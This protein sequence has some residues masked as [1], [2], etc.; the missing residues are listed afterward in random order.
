MVA[1][2]SRTLFHQVPRVEA[3]ELARC[4]RRSMTI[5]IVEYAIAFMCASGSGVISRSSPGAQRAQAADAR[6]PLAGQQEIVVRQHAAL[7]PAGGAGGVEQRAFGVARAGRA[8]LRRRG[9]A[10]AA[11]ASPMLSGPTMHQL[12]SGLAQ[13]RR[14]GRRRA[15]A[16][17]TARHISLWP[18][19]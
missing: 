1:R 6:V 10:R 2:D 12:A 16:A 17:L 9:M 3:V 5:A 15:R 19:R 14:A 13:R 4:S 11:T 7:G 8:G 18:S